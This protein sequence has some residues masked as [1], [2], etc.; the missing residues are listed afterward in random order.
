MSAKYLS[1]RIELWL[2]LKKEPSLDT[3]SLVK[4]YAT[5]CVLPD[6]L[7]SLGAYN[8]QSPTV[9]PFLDLVGSI[10]GIR[11]ALATDW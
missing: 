10:T 5:T 2:Y 11:V 9:L 4:C 8:I 3:V 7:G 1:F 6:G